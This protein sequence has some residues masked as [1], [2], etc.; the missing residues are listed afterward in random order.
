MFKVF[1]LKEAESLDYQLN[2]GRTFAGKFSP[3]AGFGA[4]TVFIGYLCTSYFIRRSMIL[5][6]L[7]DN[8]SSK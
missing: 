7:P 5:G 1:N 4:A 3:D 2:T 8:N 6:N